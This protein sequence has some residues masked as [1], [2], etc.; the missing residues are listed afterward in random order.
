MEL[1]PQIKA[2]LAKLDYQIESVTSGELFDFAPSI[3]YAPYPYGTTYQDGTHGVL[4]RLPDNDNKYNNGV[5][6]LHKLK[7]GEIVMEVIVPNTRDKGNL[8]Q[9]LTDSITNHVD[10]L[11]TFNL[12]VYDYVDIWGLVIANTVVKPLAKTLFPADAVKREKFTDLYMPRMLA[13][14]ARLYAG[15]SKL[16]EEGINSEPYVVKMMIDHET[17]EAKAKANKPDKPNETNK[18]GKSDKSDKSGKSDK[19]KHSAAEKG[20]VS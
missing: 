10:G 1:T 20:K 15:D 8:I 5:Y 18:S 11:D 9:T 4:M 16:F 6:M 3:G 2:N 7:G 13:N 14:I 17:A 19:S 12:N